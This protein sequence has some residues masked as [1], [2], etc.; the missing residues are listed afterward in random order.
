[1]SGWVI[2][3]VDQFV[4]LHAELRSRPSVQKRQIQNI[5]NWHRRNPNAILPEEKD[6]INEEEDLMTIVPCLKTPLQRVLERTEWFSTSSCF[7]SKRKK[8]AA[9]N[10]PEAIFFQSEEKVRILDTTIVLVIGLFM[11]LTPIWVL[12]LLVK[13]TKARLGIISAFITLFLFGIQAVTAGKP[14]ETLAATAA[15][16]FYFLIK[17][18][19]FWGQRLT[20]LSFSYSAVLMVFVQATTS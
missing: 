1:M 12:G 8:N 2:T 18:R 19:E 3:R 11:L 14:G 16:V 7:R 13:H 5:K 9:F 4:V 10:D 6:Y 17:K 20:N 15:Y